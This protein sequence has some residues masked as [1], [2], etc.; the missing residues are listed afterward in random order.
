[1]TVLV[2]GA[3]GNVG[4]QLV[5]ELLD[6]D[7]PVRAL[8]RDPAKADLPEGVEVVAGDLTD[9]T[10]LT[11]A[12]RGAEALHLINAAGADY[13]PLAHGPEIVRLATEA[14]VRRVTFVAGGDDEPAELAV[15][16]SDLEW[17]VLRPTEFMSNSLEWT[18]TIRAEG[19]VRAGFAGEKTTVIDPADIAAVA[20]VVLTGGG[21]ASET[22]AL[23][24]REAL[25]PPDRA[26]IIGEVIGR[27][28]EFVAL[29]NAEVRQQMRDQGIDDDVADFVIAWHSDPP[30]EGSAIDPTVERITGRAPSTFAEW[31]TANKEV[32]GG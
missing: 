26:R 32:F 30:A 10:T 8:T 3:T 2:T 7:T 5:R 23:T 11:G 28:I 19:V 4:S 18:D 31:V 16:A 25:T 21:H 13:A 20:A 12:L 15:R 6:R 29:S 17:T 22:L 24:G 9:P 27:P 14:G 1:M